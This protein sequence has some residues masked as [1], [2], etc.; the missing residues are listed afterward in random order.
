MNI[1]HGGQLEDFSE[2]YGIDPEKIIDF[3]VNLNPMG[4]P[5]PII[6]L[7][8]DRIRIIER[9]PDIESRCIRGKIADYLSVKYENIIVGNGS[10]ELIYLL[11]HVYD[12]S[13]VLIVHPTYSEYERGAKIGGASV[14]EFI[15]NWQD[16]FSLDIE[17]LIQTA[18]N[19]DFVFI[20]NPNNPTGFLVSR[21]IIIELLS[22]THQTSFIIDEAFIDFV[23]D[24]KE[25]EVVR[26]IMQ[27][28][29]LVVLRSM[30]KFFAIPGLRLGYLVANEEII[31]RLNQIKEPWSVN[32]L[33]QLVGEYLLDQSDY[34]KRSLKLIE[35]ERAFLISQLSQ[36]GWLYIYPSEVNFLLVRI[37][38][39]KLDSI[40]LNEILMNNGFAIRDCSNFV[41]LDNKFFRIAVKNH[42]DNQ[43]L[44]ELLR[45]I[46]KNFL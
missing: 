12:K 30:T 41:G 6:E 40:K 32:V 31:K 42:S 9:Y 39:E 11:F 21:E 24:R 17:K 28:H 45:E 14:D 3:S 33:A 29:N 36:L 20:C 27:F 38:T 8:K 22:S 16:G 23:H 43:K 13:R 25:Y 5:E 46:G 10:N 44:I 35:E 1:R 26:E 19:Y 4:A 2:Q 34:V 18:Q 37:N 15:L 7:L